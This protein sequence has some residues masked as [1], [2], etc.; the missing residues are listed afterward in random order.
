[1]CYDKP[2]DIFIQLSSSLLSFSI[3]VISDTKSI[4]NIVKPKQLSEPLWGL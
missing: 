2:I 3:K 4:Y 1:M